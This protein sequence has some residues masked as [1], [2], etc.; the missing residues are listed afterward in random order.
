[1]ARYR[2]ATDVGIALAI[3]R[4]HPSPACVTLLAGRKYRDYL[5][6]LLA[7]AGHMVE[8]PLEGRGIGQ[9]L[10]WLNARLARHTRGRQIRLPF[11]DAT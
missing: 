6:P 1:M 11:E 9:Q 2:R 7:E 5:A 4:R 10:S 8:V 3:A